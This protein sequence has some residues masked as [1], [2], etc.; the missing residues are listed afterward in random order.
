MVMGGVILLIMI[1]RNRE[2]LYSDN[3]TDEPFLECEI[4]LTLVNNEYLISIGQC[5]AF[6]G[7]LTSLGPMWKHFLCLLVASASSS[8]ISILLI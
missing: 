4:R 7:P 2:Y 5:N 3:S 1:D 8:L 6:F